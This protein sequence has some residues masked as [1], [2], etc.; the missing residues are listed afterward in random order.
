MSPDHGVALEPFLMES[1]EI[2][3]GPAS[4][5]YGNSAIGGAVNAR[6]R[7]LARER[8]DRPVAELP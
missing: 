2:H 5:L 1:V 7:V 8:I 3:R 6:S 4:L